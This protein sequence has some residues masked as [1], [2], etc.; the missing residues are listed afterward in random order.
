MKKL[1]L[2]LPLLALAPLV[3]A[4][5]EDPATNAPAADP[6][7][8]VGAKAVI[9]AALR[10]EPKPAAETNGW[11]RFL[12][13][14]RALEDRQA[15][16]RGAVDPAAWLAAVDLAL[17]VE[18]DA[19]RTI[20]AKAA[21]SNGDALSP[22]VRGEL[23]ALLSVLP[24]PSGWDAIRAG[25][26]ERA[27]RLAAETVV[28]TAAATDA[29]AEPTEMAAVRH[30]TVLKT[31]PVPEGFNFLPA[32]GSTAKVEVR[33]EDKNQ[34]G[35]EKKTDGRPVLLAALRV[36][37][38]FLGG[39]GR[40]AP[41][42]LAALA[43]LPAPELLPTNR[44]EKAVAALRRAMENPGVPAKAPFS[45]E[46]L[47]RQIDRLRRTGRSFDFPDAL[48]LVKACGR[49]FA[50]ALCNP[51]PPPIWN[52]VAAVVHDAP[53]ASLGIFVGPEGDF[54]PEELRALLEL[55]TPVS[56]G[57]TILR[58][59]TAAI[60]GLSVLAAAGHASFRRAR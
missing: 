8:I 30:R 18:P 23:R 57:P 50:G 38:D 5:A 1:A 53:A 9:A 17:A 35:K 40:G 45:A 48:A 24:G 44:Q 58:A 36:A 6:A 29:P 59:E 15:E 37:A 25:L 2:L 55:A 39:G 43:A 16:T 49:V 7:A 56:F 22:T 42:S 47:L 3:A 46:R 20:D 4:R 26:R 14:V 28:G 12:L 54:T 13:A 21:P 11:D 31:K 41:E 34:D 51:P 19:R 10:P 33:P 32:S 60:F 27:E 52:E